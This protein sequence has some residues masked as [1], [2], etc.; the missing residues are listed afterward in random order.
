[1]PPCVR[2][3]GTVGRLLSQD[4]VGALVSVVSFVF[5]VV[6][7]AS[8]ATGVQPPRSRGEDTERAVH[9][10]EVPEMM[11]ITRGVRSA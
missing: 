7:V 10:G 6:G 9:V 4:F 3:L 1:V 5:V 11:R 2:A 8:S